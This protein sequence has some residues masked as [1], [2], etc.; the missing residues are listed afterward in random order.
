MQSERTAVR[1]SVPVPNWFASVIVIG[2][3][4]DLGL[5]ARHSRLAEGFVIG[6]VATWPPLLT[7]VFTGAQCNC[8]APGAAEKLPAESLLFSDTCDGVAGN[9]TGTAAVL[10]EAAR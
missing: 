10:V 8:T 7:T 1:L 2:S 9:G 4:D 5:I 6:V 3:L